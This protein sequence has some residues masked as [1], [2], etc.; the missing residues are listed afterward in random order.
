[1]KLVAVVGASLA[2]LSSAR[3]LREQGFDGRLVIVGAERHRPY[4]RP[5]LSKEFL[6]GTA[7]EA[8]LT[9]ESDD[10]DLDA[11][12]RLGT[13]VTSLEAGSRLSLSDGS[14]LSVDGIVL[15][16]GAQ[17]RRLPQMDQLA[18]LHL[19]RTLEDARAL[20][21]DLKPGARLVVVGAGFIGAEVASTA[22]GL[23][24]DVTVL[25]AATSPLAGA[26]GEQMGQVVSGLHADHGVTLRCGVGVAAIEGEDHVSGVRLADGTLVPADVV[27]VGVG[28]KP[29]TD[30]LAGSDIDIAD[31]VLCDAYGATSVEH[32]V[33]VG[34]CST[35]YDPATR[36]HQRLEHWTAARER[37]GIAVATLL[38]G[39]TD[40]RVGRPPYFWSDQYG[41][42]IQFTGHITGHDEVTVDEG[43]IAERDFVAV[44]R[45]A[46]E[47]VGVIAV[48][49]GKAFTRWR[50][51]L[52]QHAAANA[53]SRAE[54]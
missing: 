3:A 25:E 41:G 27:L 4:D 22:S 40:Q 31:G 49:R 39:G 48:N 5:P 30:W 1:V 43:S 46:G 15:A 9:L 21:A 13:M 45:R 51:Q 23:G 32:V 8:D 12:W 44:Y 35:W 28:V 14:T 54:E 33:A 6:G 50:R 47:P 53:H 37:A 11:E 52:A 18:G 42:R 29:T 16:T 38:S 36:R 24:V 20:R 17:P 19:L 7:S 34:D 2:G 26:I 10:E